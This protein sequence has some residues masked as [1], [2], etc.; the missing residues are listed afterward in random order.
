MSF[1]L[2]VYCCALCGA[3]AGLA[4]WLLGL[5]FA[6]LS[7][8]QAAGMQGLCLGLLVGLVLGLVDALWDLPLSRVGAVAARVGT[9]GAVACAG[10]LVGGI[11]AQGF[12][13]RFPGVLSRMIAWGGAGLL[14]GMALAAFEVIS[15]SLQRGGPRG[16]QKLAKVALGGCLGGLLGGLVLELVLRGL[17]GVFA[18]KAVPLRFPPATG[19][20]V[21]GAI[22]G[23]LIGLAQVVLKEAWIKVEEGFRAGREL[24]LSRPEFTI[25]RAES[26]DIGL[27]GDPTVERLHARIVQQPSG[28]VLV[29]ETVGRTLV[30]ERQVG[31]GCPLRNGDRI[32][33]GRNVLVFGERRKH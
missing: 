23:L 24:L 8:M 25:G 30:N 11:M 4:A 1:R 28:Y 27:F 5:A 2:F 19:F 31:Q 6:R 21:L 20:T 3:W 26:C 9:A 7:A 29:D 32:R 16:Y 15:A 13:G 22:L 10:G 14:I 18:P 12:Y 33:I 17:T